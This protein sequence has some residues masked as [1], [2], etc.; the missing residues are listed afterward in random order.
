MGSRGG[1]DVAERH[2]V[3]SHSQKHGECKKVTVSWDGGGV[4][5]RLGLS[6]GLT[7]FQ[8]ERAMAE[9]KVSYIEIALVKWEGGKG[10]IWVRQTER[11][12]FHDQQR[13][14]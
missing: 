9:I 8:S 13:N 7:A 12:T 2:R 11:K 4:T 10:K 5:A 14:I 3:A 6:Y 1:G